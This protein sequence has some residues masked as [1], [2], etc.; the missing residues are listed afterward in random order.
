[1]ARWRA[2]S[3]VLLL[4]RTDGLWDTP[5]GGI[6][7]GE[8]SWQ[9]GKR[10]AFEEAGVFV[11]EER[12]GLSARGRTPGGGTYS[13]FLVRARGLFVPTLDPTEHTDFAWAARPTPGQ[14]LVPGLRQELEDLGIW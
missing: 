4:R 14:R 13:L 1:M 10:E 9:A 5:G 2:T 7:P 3:R 8:D 11:T 12:P 6:E